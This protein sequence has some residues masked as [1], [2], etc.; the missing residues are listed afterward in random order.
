MQIIDFYNHKRKVMS[1]YPSSLQLISEHFDHTMHHSLSSLSR[2]DNQIELMRLSD[3]D[4]IKDQK[5]LPKVLLHRNLLNL[6]T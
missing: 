5:Y 1:I 6:V 3:K 4:I 2:I